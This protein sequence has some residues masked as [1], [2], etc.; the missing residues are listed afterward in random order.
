MLPIVKAKLLEGKKG[1]I[2]GIV[3]SKIRSPGD[4]PRRFGRSAQ[5]WPLHM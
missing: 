3:G 5:K 2:V 4:A 1:L